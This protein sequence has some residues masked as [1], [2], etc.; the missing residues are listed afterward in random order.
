MNYFL[1]VNIFMFLWV[2]TSFAGE[3]D[4][5]EVKAIKNDKN[6]YEFTVTVSHEDTGWKHYANKWDIVD[7]NG[8]VLGSR[9]LYHP[10]VNEQPFSRSLSG[11]IIPDSIKS[12][13]VRAHDLVH[14]YG[15]KT[16]SVELP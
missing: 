11:I 16:M 15:G 8:N 14:G 13:T 7:N 2:T 12:V 3:A 6:L 9:I 4:V 1:L 10:H 5:L